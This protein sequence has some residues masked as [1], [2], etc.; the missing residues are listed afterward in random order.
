MQ[1]RARHRTRCAFP[2]R[3]H[4]PRTARHGASSCGGCPRA[5]GGACMVR[6]RAICGARRA[7]RRVDGTG[8]A[9]C[10]SIAPR[11]GVGNNGYLS[12][13]PIRSVGAHKHRELAHARPTSVADRPAPV[14][15]WCPLH[16]WAH[17][18]TR[19]REGK[20][21]TR[22]FQVPHGRGS[23]RGMAIPW[24]CETDGPRVPVRIVHD[25]T[26]RRHHVDRGSPRRSWGSA[27]CALVVLVS[28]RYSAR[29][30][31]LSS[32]LRDR[33]RVAVSRCTDVTARCGRCAKRR[34][35]GHV[36]R[37]G[38]EAM[39]R[40][41]RILVLCMLLSVHTA[42][43]DDATVLPQGVWRVGA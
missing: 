31:S 5:S 11:A 21:A 26:W 29:G 27:V 40:M 25:R 10:P 16:V 39:A 22:A 32:A 30:S 36:Q 38:G 24:W 15:S 34:R 12:G 28:P 19:R 7:H 8:G 17:A 14:G 3:V 41:M 37:A 6:G 13:Q 4:P 20:R 42:V 43:A 23:C 1:P 33:R 9:V 18:R 2:T 35:K